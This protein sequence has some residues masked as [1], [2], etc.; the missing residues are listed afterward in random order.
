MAC[1][2]GTARNPFTAVPLPPSA[3]GGTRSSGVLVAHRHPAV[4]EL[5]VVLHV[6]K[7]AV[8]VVVIFC[9]SLR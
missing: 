4:Q 1:P 6:I 7:L 9:R 3:T 2:R 8:V 5:R